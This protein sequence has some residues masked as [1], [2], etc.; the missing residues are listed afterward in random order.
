MSKG[1]PLEDHL[2]QI[3][4]LQP[5]KF[6]IDNLVTSMGMPASRLRKAVGWLYGRGYVKVDS[7]VD[8]KE[9]WRIA[10]IQEREST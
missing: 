7:V 5:G 10:T 9:V 4:N 2:L 1:T 6:T 3:M 8:G